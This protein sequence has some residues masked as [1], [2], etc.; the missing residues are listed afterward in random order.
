VS[1]ATHDPP[2]PPAAVLAALARRPWAAGLTRQERA[3][4][5]L[6]LAGAGPREAARR[7]MVSA[8]TRKAHVRG[9]LAK[10]GAANLGAL[11]ND[12]LREAVRFGATEPQGADA[13]RGPDAAAR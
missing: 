8:N 5:T 3:A 10:A 1:P 7:M 4:L 11:V 13:P 9:L 2:E 12:L 6:A